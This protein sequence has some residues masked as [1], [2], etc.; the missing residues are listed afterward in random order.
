MTGSVGVAATGRRATD[1]RRLVSCAEGTPR[2]ARWPVQIE[3][4]EEHDGDEHRRDR[5]VLLKP[6]LVELSD[7]S[8]LERRPGGERNAGA[9]RV[10]ATRGL[11]CKLTAIKNDCS[12]ILNQDQLTPGAL[13]VQAVDAI[14]PLAA[15][16]RLRP[17]G[18]RLLTLATP[19]ANE[20]GSALNDLIRSAF[21]GSIRSSSD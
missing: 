14:A 15:P 7:P 10:P 12:L 4:N 9:V 20:S 1:A 18:R 17:T 8:L 13:N 19:D 21:R 11:G 5:D 6:R 3:G 2:D 16:R